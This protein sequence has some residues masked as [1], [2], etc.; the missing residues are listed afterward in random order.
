[1]PL[2]TGTA[3]ERFGTDYRHS[4]QAMATP[5]EV[6]IE[7]DD[8]KIAEQAFRAAE[9]EA[10]RIEAK[11]S[12]YL[13]DSIV[14]R[15]NANAGK[16]FQVD[17]ETAQILSFAAHCF[18]LSNGLF[19]ITS[20]ILRRVWRFDGSDRVPGHEEVDGLRKFVGWERVSWEPPI[21]RLPAGA[22]I[23]L[24]GLGKEYAVDRALQSIREKTNQPAL[25]NF[26][27][28]LSVSG[29]RLGNFS[30]TVAIESVDRAGQAEGMLEIQD[31]AIATSGDARRFLLKDGVRY[32]HVLDPRTGWP[33]ADPLRS[34]TVA[35]PTCVQAGIIATLA[36][37]QGAQAEAFLKRERVRAWYIR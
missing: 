20:G 17:E 26:G 22:E 31:G 35:A 33:V 12:R 36:I 6:R 21:I 18:E 19:D 28:D 4:F 16:E 23:D 10:R 32:G 5:C 11:F 27:G 3:F 9:N 13:P 30:W 14:S 25:V 8:A 29:P 24:G 37:L 34:V 2:C 1:M 7:T 15:I